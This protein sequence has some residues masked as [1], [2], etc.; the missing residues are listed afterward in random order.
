MEDVQTA[1]VV[2]KFF[3]P[4]SSLSIIE[5][6]TRF[7]GISRKELDD[8]YFFSKIYG[9]DI[10]GD[11]EY[12]S[13]EIPLFQR[14]ELERRI[15]KISGN[16]VFAGLPTSGKST[17]INILHHITGKQITS[18][19]LIKEMR[20]LQFCRK[21]NVTKKI[22][23]QNFSTLM[24]GTFDG[25]YRDW[26]TEVFKESVVESLKN[27]TLLDIGGYNLLR[28]QEYLFLKQNNINIIYIDIGRE[29]WLAKSLA[30]AKERPDFMEV[31]EQDTTIDKRV[32]Q[33]FCEETYDLKGGVCKTRSDF[34]IQ[35][36]K[37]N[38]LE[39][40]LQ[41]I[42]ILHKQEKYKF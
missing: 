31:Y 27:G 18:Y 1:S 10:Y 19:D 11:L 20:K 30:L 41:S 4:T 25:S 9:L 8:F 17:L 23:K 16:F 38:P 39:L 29:M 34:I 21:F 7:F 5:Y 33:K 37:M 3:T 40:L 42:T 6:G 28:E 13:S 26:L 22:F 36:K 12:S 24:T 15:A 32:Y 2:T 35:R 14:R